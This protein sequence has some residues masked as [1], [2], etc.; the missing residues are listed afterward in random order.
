MAACAHIS[1]LLLVCCACHI[2]YGLCAA[3]L[4][5]SGSLKLA[6]NGFTWRRAQGG[7]VV[8]VKKDGEEAVRRQLTMSGYPVCYASRRS[9]PSHYPPYAGPKLAAQANPIITSLHQPLAAAQPGWT[10]HA[11]GLMHDSVGL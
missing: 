11:L 1:S 3:L 10:R 4:Q 6:G 5:T 8:E 2:L 9:P 7:K